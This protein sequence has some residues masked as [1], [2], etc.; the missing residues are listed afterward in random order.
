MTTLYLP[1][2]RRKKIP[3]RADVEIVQVREKR[4]LALAQTNTKRLLTETM[5]ILNELNRFDLAAVENGA[6]IFLEG[7]GVFCF[8][9]VSFTIGRKILDYAK[10]YLDPTDVKSVFYYRFHEFIHDYLSG[11]WPQARDYDEALVDRSLK[12]GEVYHVSA[13][14][15]LCG[16]LRIERGDF[17]DARL[18]VDKL[19]EISELFDHD[20]S[21]GAAYLLNSLLLLK[22][23]RLHDAVKEAD[24]GISH[25]MKNGQEMLAL[26]ASAIKINAHI[27]LHEAAGAGDLLV[28]TGEFVARK[29]LIAPFYTGNLA[30]S[31]S[32][33][34]ISLM[35]ASLNGGDGRGTGE[36]KSI[37]RRSAR[38]AVRNA[39]N[40]AANKTE[41]QRLMGIHFCLCGR[42]GVALKW[43]G[44]SIGTGERTGARP[45]L[46]RTYMEVGKRLSE[47]NSGHRELNGM[48][49]GEF[50][51]RAETLFIEMGLEWDLEELAR[52]R[53]SVS[54]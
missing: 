45:E 47:K 52:V 38:T 8:S 13:Y 34:D 46:A 3:D 22:Q 28:P 30:I 18:L 44:K 40:Y 17:K 42:R 54:A 25:L 21:R 51:M 37:S 41:A 7:C 50:L 43:F 33:F 14:T 4:A 6:P 49:P 16:L 26:F 24:A 23:R 36:L 29:K 31:R 27:L 20:Y 53:E 32:L 19:R 35:E 2:R 1:S 15:M 48:K 11:N 39:A 10:G 12:T 9:G 5:G